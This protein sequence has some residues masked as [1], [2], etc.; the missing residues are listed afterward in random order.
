MEKTELEKMTLQALEY[1]RAKLAY[2]FDERHKHYKRSALLVFLESEIDK[3]TRIIEKLRNEKEEAK[4][5]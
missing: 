1:R 2:L 5:W 3:E 4:R